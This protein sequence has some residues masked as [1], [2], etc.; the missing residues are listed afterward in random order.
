MG[1]LRRVPLNPR[2][3]CDILG[4]MKKKTLIILLIL[5][6]CLAAF[7]YWWNRTI[8]EDMYAAADT[9][10]AYKLA[11]YYLAWPVSTEKAFYAHQTRGY[12][13]E[14]K[15]DN[16]GAQAEYVAARRWK[17]NNEDLNLRLGDVLVDQGKYSQA[18]YYY[19]YVLQ[20]NEQ[21][22]LGWSQLGYWYYKTGEDDRARETWQKAI[23]IDSQIEWPNW[24]LGVLYLAD[25]L[26]GSLEKLKT[27]SEK[28]DF[29]KAGAAGEI[30]E[31]LESVGLEGR[32]DKY[33][34]VVI[35]RALNGAGEPEL[36]LSYVDGTA[37]EDG[38]YRDAFVVRGES[39]YLL[40]RSQLAREDFE[41][42]LELDPD[43]EEIRGFLSKVK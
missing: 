41:K 27:V 13:L 28:T 14:S 43:N 24:Y 7:S 11:G 4:D 23:E 5:V 6:I 32:N 18:L 26:E 35:A 30:V 1:K 9:G 20:K 21:S 34:K 25:D 33:R 42:A 36:A 38:G 29:E 19:R 8:G 22:A 40:R 10:E 15:G 37:E 2:S 16:V 17:R 39:Y 12:L 3:R 31:G